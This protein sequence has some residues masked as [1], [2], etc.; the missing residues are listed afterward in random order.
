M[1]ITPEMEQV[2]M[3][4]SSRLK[5][6]DGAESG[7]SYFS[8]SRTGHVGSSDRARAARAPFAPPIAQCLVCDT[9]ILGMGLASGSKRTV[10]SRIGKCQMERSVIPQ[11]RAD[12]GLWLDPQRAFGGPR[13]NNAALPN[14]PAQSHLVDRVLVEMARRRALADALRPPKRRTSSPSGAPRAKLPVRRAS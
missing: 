13:V 14:E 11:R 1:A 7:S 4:G 8:L 10:A 6:R 3:T 12:S 5:G 9:R 2:M